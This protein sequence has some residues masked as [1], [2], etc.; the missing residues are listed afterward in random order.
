MADGVVA[1]SAGLALDESILT[2]ESDHVPKAPGDQV[3]SGAYCASGCGLYRVTAVGADS[4]ASRADGRGPA[5]EAAA[6]DAAAR[7]QPPAAAAAARD[8]AARDH[9]R[10]SAADPR[11]RLPRGRPDRHGRPHLDRARGARAAGVGDVRGRRRPHRP[12]RRARAA[13]E[14]DR[15]ARVGRHGLPRQD[16]HAHRRHASSWSRWCRRPASRRPR[17]AGAGA[18]GGAGSVRS[19]TSDAIAAALGG[20]PRRRSPRCR[21]RR[22]G[23]GRA[24]P[25]RDA[26]LVLGAPEVLGAGPLATEVSRRQGERSRVLVFGRA[27]VAAPAAAAAR[28]RRS[29]RLHAARPRVLRERMRPEAD[30]VVAYLR[31]RAST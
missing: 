3:L 2:G 27:D 20:S 5:G 6:V 18:G 29:A 10:R 19:G 24:S 23:S 15:V 21:S 30:E 22:A 11:H 28:A 16:R 7:D 8:G 1:A 4:Y 12:G 26:V 9:P 17:A 31:R 13:A 25:F 14:R